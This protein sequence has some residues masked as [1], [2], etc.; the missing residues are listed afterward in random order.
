MVSA[1]K[2]NLASPRSNE[3]EWIT[4]V[5]VCNGEL[6][7]ELGPGSLL[8]DSRRGVAS[9]ILGFKGKCTTNGFGFKSLIATDGK[10][11]SVEHQ[12]QSSSLPGRMAIIKIAREAPISPI[13]YPIYKVLK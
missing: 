7:M 5:V 6:G 11:I 8:E 2:D 13:Q 10:Q 4:L 9:V 1:S 12:V 3:G